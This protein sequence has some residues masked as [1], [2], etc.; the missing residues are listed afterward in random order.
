E[1]VGERRVRTREFTGAT[2][3]FVID[4]QLAAWRRPELLDAFEAA[5]VRN[6]ECTQLLDR[7]APKLDPDRM[8]GSRRE[9]VDDA[10]A[11]RKMATPF[12]EVDAFVGEPDQS[13]YDVIE[14]DGVTGADHQWLDVREPGDQRLQQPAD[15][16][17]GD[18]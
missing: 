6:R 11:H 7:V 13:A 10:A 4:Q 14:V 17:D 12:D 5:L 3:Y 16:S 18:G 15:R 8:F 1:D 9:H 2:A